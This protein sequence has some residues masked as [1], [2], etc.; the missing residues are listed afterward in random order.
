MLEKTTAQTGN[1]TNP[2]QRPN[3]ALLLT[4]AYSV[5]KSLVR[6]KDS[7]RFNA[8]RYNKII[9]SILWYSDLQDVED[10]L[11]R[12]LTDKISF[13]NKLSIL[14][15]PYF[16][17]IYS[18][19]KIFELNIANDSRIFDASITGSTSLSKNLKDSVRKYNEKLTAITKNKKL[20][21]YLKYCDSILKSLKDTLSE[22][23]KGK[24]DTLAIKVIAVDWGGELKNKLSAIADTLSKYNF[25]QGNEKKQFDA[26]QYFDSTFLS[27]NNLII[28]LIRK[29]DDLKSSYND[30]G[31]AYSKDSTDIRN[32][33][34]EF[35]TTKKDSL[36][37]FFA[38]MLNIN[39]DHSESDRVEL[40]ETSHPFYS[41]KEK[42]IELVYQTPSPGS[43]WRLP[44][45]S[46]MIDAISIYLANRV[47]QE[48]VIWFFEQLTNNIKTYDLLKIFFPST[49]TLLQS[50]EVYE[51][52]NMGAQ[53]RYGLS[54]D[55]TNMPR[56]VLCSQWFKDRW[57]HVEKYKDYLVGACD[58]ADL[59]QKR[60]SY[61]DI[62]KQL[63]LTGSNEAANDSSINFRDYI[64]LLYAV[65]TE[66]FL[67]DS[68]SKYR[69]LKYED[70][71]S[72]S[73]DEL[74]IMLS[75]IDMKYGGVLHKFLKN[76]Y[77][78]FSISTP[79]EAE[80]IRKW[81]G[82]IEVAVSQI[83]KA[84]LDFI[85]KE[86]NNSKDDD[87]KGFFNHFNIWNSLDALLH[88]LNSANTLNTDIKSIFS[89]KLKDS[90][91]AISY[92]DQIHEIYGQISNKN[93]AGAVQTTLTL[94]DSLLYG[95]N[96]DANS[97]LSYSFRQINSL[98]NKRQA[99]ILLQTIRVH[100]FKDFSD[101][102]LYG[103]TLNTVAKQG[104]PDT[105]VSFTKH[106]P[107]AA[108]I[109]EKDRHAI[110]MIRRL[111]GFLN[112]AAMANGDKQLAKV[113][114]SYALP[115]GSYKRKRNNWWS[116]D[117][118]AFVGPYIGYEKTLN[119]NTNIKTSAFNQGIVYGI[120]APIGISLSKTLGRHLR[121][122]G[123]KRYTIDT[124][125]TDFILNPDLIKLKQKN[126]YTRTHSTFT[127]TVS[128]V[129]LGA[130]VSYRFTHQDTTSLP[131]LKWSQ[132]ISP[133]LHIAYGI[134]NTP[135]VASLGIQYTPQLRS[136]DKT[137]RQYNAIRCYAG[138]LFDLPLITLWERKRIVYLTSQ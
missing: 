13:Y 70:Y 88:F 30:K 26:S 109:F 89:D 112:D 72:M 6:F 3:D 99:P 17:N 65:N 5:A 134:R 90:K 66:L 40:E 113:V 1:T 135:L 122:A 118:N 51:I 116:L 92:I 119:V 98:I 67:P 2:S 32:N 82:A 60:F 11:Y 91:T 114:E 4:N 62:V 31:I 63:Y 34:I 27:S 23:R 69:L 47:K 93:F 130:V 22:K 125:A 71:R 45:E 108:M 41:D 12:K 33:T 78:S 79:G 56:N 105:I 39:T 59:L 111:S 42:S 136:L 35:L 43:T 38:K 73:K 131:Q 25:I 110:A 86:D 85:K 127:L 20:V 44:S 133:G 52:P 129:D 128:L 76:K 87:N 49:M 50:R 7:T 68:V 64:N 132:F 107:M 74:E 95:Y 106:S 126:M 61:K 53:W 101:S 102:M 46:E 100:A 9:G 103:F 15:K 16:F 104:I 8:D 115:I 84:R 121:T 21:E 75:L 14:F 10:T 94:I 54:K 137:D 117:F 58:I 37:G 96:D 97:S 55:F 83:E 19:Q 18:T 24:P 77:H 81:L 28:N 36:S 124:S 123:G 120:T 29:I 57:P 48:A 80:N 138:V